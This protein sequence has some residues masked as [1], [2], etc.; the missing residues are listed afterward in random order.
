MAR[1]SRSAASRAETL[2]AL[3][4]LRAPAARQR[5]VADRRAMGGRAAG[6]RGDHAPVVRLA[7]PLGARRRADRT[8]QRRLRRSRCRRMGRCRALRGPRP[9]W[10]RAAATAPPSP[11][12]GRPASRARACG[13]ATRSQASDRTARSRPRPST[14]GAATC[15]RSNRGSRSI[16]SSVGR[17]DRRRARGA[18]RRASVP[19]AAVAPP[20]ARPVS[21]GPAGRRPRGVPP[22]PLRPG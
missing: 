20:D 5:R 17:R 8:G 4:A 13:A 12:R 19:G 14:R 9:W 2:L 11:G 6:W 1:R 16:S 15:M 21:R 18:R 10:A 22:R 3:L 7:P